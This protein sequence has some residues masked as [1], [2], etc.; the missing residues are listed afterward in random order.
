MLAAMQAR[1]PALPWMNEDAP[2]AVA[3]L[4]AL[5][6]TEWFAGTRELRV[7]NC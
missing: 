4:Q 6:L 5:K 2:F 3:V 1:H 7:P